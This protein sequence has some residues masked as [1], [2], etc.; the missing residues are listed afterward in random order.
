[1]RYLVLKEFLKIRVIFWFFL[2]AILFC[3]AWNY[4]EIKNGL[5]KFGAVSYILRVIYSKFYSLNH[6]DEI[7]LLFAF[8]VGFASMFYER[9]NARIRVQFAY[10]HTFLANICTLAL[11]PLL[12]LGA[13]YVAEIAIMRWVF[14]MFFPSELSNALISTLS[15]SCF[16]GICIYFLVASLLIEPSIIRVS[17]TAIVFLATLFLYFKINPDIGN[18]S[19]YYLNEKMW[20]FLSLD[21]I[22]CISSYVISLNN[23]KKGYIK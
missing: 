14:G 21:L 9:L 2:V 15:Y 7:N 3:C 6:L 23:Y 20:I 17:G 4:I 11:T 10:P 13:V 8:A 1:M 16:F 5:D 12:F 22:F 19:L 18:S